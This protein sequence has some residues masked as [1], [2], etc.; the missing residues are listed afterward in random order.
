[1]LSLHPCQPP[2]PAPAPAPSQAL[3]ELPCLHSPAGRGQG[4]AQSNFQGLSCCLC[5]FLPTFS[6][7]VS[8]LVCCSNLCNSSL[9]PIG[10]FSPSVFSEQLYS[11][12][13]TCRDNHSLSWVRLRDQTCS[14]SHLSLFPF[15]DVGASQSVVPAV[16]VPVKHLSPQNRAKFLASVAHPLSDRVCVAFTFDFWNCCSHI[17]LLISHGLGTSARSLHHRWSGH[18]CIPTESF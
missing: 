16:L 4:Q 5:S 6:H 13:V 10:I 17:F 7:G 1:M 15:A 12:S 9:T 14:S 3:Q 8:V 2:L 11:F 18:L